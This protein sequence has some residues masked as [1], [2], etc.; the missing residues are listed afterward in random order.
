MTELQEIWQQILAPYSLLS[1]FSILLR[2]L[3]AFLLGSMVAIV[4][5]WTHQSI[6]NTSFTDTLVML[7]ML[8]A[9]VMVVIGD[10]VARAFSLV[11]ALSIIRFRTVVRDPRDIAFVFFAL[12]VGMG[13]GAGNQLAAITGTFVISLIVMGIT[14]FRGIAVEKGEFI[15]ELTILPEAEDSIY[16]PIFSQM[17]STYRQ[18]SQAIS[19][20]GNMKLEFYVRLKDPVLWAKFAQQ[21]RQQEQISSVSIA[22]N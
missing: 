11:G 7:C 15:L 2:L 5:R 14:Y 17:L 9:I 19:K 16:Q 18:T 3:L 13:I 20:S 8:I 22:E 21:L 6:A 1:V 12:A 10:S 4:Y